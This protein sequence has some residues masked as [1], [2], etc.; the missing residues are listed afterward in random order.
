MAQEHRANAGRIAQERRAHVVQVVRSWEAELNRRWQA[1]AQH[2]QSVIILPSTE[3]QH[4]VGSR[5][6][7]LERRRRISTG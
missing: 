3:P 6:C 1:H 5:C 4:R 2:R 7:G